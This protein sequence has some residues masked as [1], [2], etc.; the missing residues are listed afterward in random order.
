M[1][2][3]QGFDE[4]LGHALVQATMKIKTYLQRIAARVA[5]G[6][7]AGNNACNLIPR[8]DPFEIGGCIHL[9]RVITLV[10][11]L[12]GLL[13]DLLGRRVDHLPAYPAIDFHLVANLS[14]EQLINRDAEAFGFN[15]PHG[16]LDTRDRAS[17]DRT[18]TIKT[19]TIQDLKYI[20]DIV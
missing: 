20:L 8:V 10:H 14:A 12:L 11:L 17:K 18:T 9:D 2:R 15:I 1:I 5:N 13:G 16:L 6:F 4:Y 3:I 7:H 19:T